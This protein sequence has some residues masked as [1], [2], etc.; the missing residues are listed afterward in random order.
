MLTRFNMRRLGVAVTLALLSVL[1]SGTALAQA[2]NVASTCGST[3][4]PAFANA[5][6]DDAVTLPTC[7]QL[8]GVCLGGPGLVCAWVDVTFEPAGTVVFEDSSAPITEVCFGAVDTYTLQ[9]CAYSDGNLDC[10]EV[11]IAAGNGNTAP[12]TNAGINQQVTQPDDDAVLDCD[13]NDATTAEASCDYAWEQI[14]GP[15]TATLTPEDD[16]QTVASNLTE[17][18]V[19]TFLC[20]ATDDD[21]DPLSVADSL[22]VTVLEAG[23]N[24]APETDAGVDQTI[25]DP[26]S[27]TTLA[28]TCNDDVTA[29]G[30]CEYLWEFVSGPETPS[31]TSSTAASTG[32]TGLTDLGAYVFRCTA[33]DDGDPGDGLSASD[34][35]TVTVNSSDGWTEIAPSPDS[36]LIYVADDGNDS[37]DGLTTATP[38]LTVAAGIAL[39]RTGFP[40]HLYFKRG[41]TWTDQGFGR[42][43]KSGRSASEPMVISNYGTGARPQFKLSGQLTRTDGGGSSPT[44]M[45]YVHFIGLDAY[46][47]KRDPDN[48]GF[49]AGHV[50]TSVDG[51]KWVRGTRGLLIEDC[52]F[53]FYETALAFQNSDGYGLD[54]IRI[55][56]NQFFDQYGTTT[57]SQGMY[58]SETASLLVEENIFDHNGWHEDI[59]GAERTIFNH[60]M[61]IQYASAG[62]IVRNNLTM[63]ASSHG[64]QLRPGGEATG[65]F[66]W[67]NA[68]GILCAGY[69][70]STFICSDN[71]VLE[72]DDIAP[73]QL[74]GYGFWVEVATS[75]TFENNIIAHE[76]SNRA[77]PVAINNQS[78]LVLDLNENVIYDWGSQSEPNPG[79]GDP[80]R[81]VRTYNAS[82]GGAGTDAAFIAAV[83]AQNKAAWDPNYMAQAINA[84]I[85]E[86]FA[87][88][89]V[90]AGSDSLAPREDVAYT[91]NA[92]CAGTEETCQWTELSGTNCTFEDGPGALGEGECECDAT[93][94]DIDVTCDAAVSETLVLTCEGE[95]D[96]VVL[97]FANDAPTVDIG[98]LPATADVDTAFSFTNALISDPDSTPS[99]TLAEVDGGD[100]DGICT[101]S[102][103]G[104]CTSTATCRA[105]TSTCDTGGVSMTH[106]LECDTIEDTHIVAINPGVSVSAGSDSSVPIE[107]VAYTLS[108]S[109][110]G[111]GL[112]CQWTESSGTNCTFE[113]LG[114][115]YDAGECEC[116]ATSCDLDVTCDAAQSETLV[117]TCDGVADSVAHDFT[118]NAPTV[119]AGVAPDATV[120]VAFQLTTT[121]TDV[122]STPSCVLSEAD[123]DGTCT[124]ES[125]GVCTSTASCNGLDIT[126]DTAEVTMTIVVT[127]DTIVDTV[128]V[129][130]D[131]DTTEPDDIWGAAGVAWYRGDDKT[132]DPVSSWNDKI[133]ALDLVQATGSLQPPVLAAAVGGRDCLDFQNADYMALTTGW[134]AL[135]TSNAAV[136]FALVQTDGGGATDVVLE[137][138]DTS[139]SSGI[140]TRLR[141]LSTDLFENRWNFTPAVFPSATTDIADDAWALVVAWVR[142][143]ATNSGRITV[144]GQWEASTNTAGT[145][146]FNANADRMYVGASSSI[147]SQWDGPICEIFIA[148][149][150]V[151]VGDEDPL[152]TD[153]VAYFEAY[154]GEDFTLP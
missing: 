27:T 4:N 102:S 20:T 153:T 15:A 118:N 116:D 59:A 29:E 12:A 75:G 84:Y 1:Y 25:T 9:L 26:E 41:D 28:C 46:Y 139:G 47:Y 143:D 70:T 152:I 128:D 72:G 42:W 141:K 85:Q 138:T 34:L 113:D 2:T 146:V 45:D 60:S 78:A 140:L 68:I 115:E 57:H 134:N 13:C 127:C 111:T 71:V 83:R 89:S 132:G 23:G 129:V 35:I 50:N 54:N 95:E 30:A 137:I 100:P 106:E 32:I 105:L 79:Y 62:V 107:D 43:V 22:T 108:A 120:D 131:P 110:S 126:C 124:F 65:N 147:G 44:H 148:N 49:D 39:L 136:I 91:L 76:V 93:S 87:T 64:L 114:A 121:I 86:G 37:N 104:T 154:Y 3:P 145:I 117:L 99:C 38:K 63:R 149:V 6:T 52:K 103:G 58:M 142:D 144:N 133:G 24:E 109:C 11:D 17:T 21:G 90:N 53:S 33:T 135:T 123:G 7:H 67:R 16:D 125:A 150:D 31:I 61:Y 18:G 96:Q 36:R 73:S 101:I 98:T 19:Y 10:D 92:S 14:G 56:R 5:G 77:N 82:L 112:T 122:D 151:D 74:K 130:I 80:E 69:L 40:D 119:V 97:G 55:R 81:S 94:C 8:E 66:S 48:A 51:I 88:S